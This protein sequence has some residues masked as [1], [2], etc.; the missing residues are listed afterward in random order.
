MYKWK[1]FRLFF[2]LTALLFGT[3]AWPCQSKDITSSGDALIEGNL[4][5]N[6]INEYSA[7]KTAAHI[8][9]LSKFH[10]IS[11]GSPGYKAAVKYVM[12]YMNSLEIF[13]VDAIKHTADGDKI[14]LQWRSMP[15]WEINEAELWLENT[16]ER[17]TRF[18]DVPVSVFVYSNAAD[19]S[20]EAVFI[21]EGISDE[22]YKGLDVRKKFVLATGDGNTVHK[23][24]VLERGA[25]GVIVGP[26][27]N[28][29]DWFCY[30]NLIP[31]HRLRSNK[32]LRKKTTFGFSLSRIQFQKLLG[33]LERG[34]ALKLH[35]KVDARQFDTE[36]ETVTA[37]LRG[38][39][40]PEKEI[41]FSAH[42]DHYSP[43]AND[44][45][46]G[47]AS[48]LE[49]ARTMKALIEQG[50]ISR[51]KRSIRFLWVG[52]MHGFAG[53]LAEDETIGERGIAG[54]NLD[55][56]GEDLFK[57]CS[58]LTLVRTPFSNPSFIADLIEYL[59]ERVDGLQFLT[60]T[61]SRQRLNYRV[62]N[63]KGGSDHFMLSDPT[64]GIPTVNIGHDNDI[65]HHTHMDDLDK[66]DTTELKRVGI[67]ST[68]AC[69][70]L[71]DA[72][73]ANALRLATKVA[74]QSLKRMADR[75][76]RN[77]SA[78][79]AAA[80]NTKH[81]SRIAKIL[82]ESKIF[83]D[84]QTG[85]EIKAIRS[86]EKLVSSPRL[87]KLTHFLEE[88]LIMSSE[89]EKK[90]L[91]YI[92]HDICKTQNIKPEPFTLS[93]EEK[94]MREIIPERLFRGPISQY[95]FE[96]LM[97]EEIE[98]YEDYGRKDRNWSNRR[99][100]ILNFMEGQR[101]LLDIYYAVS[102]EYGRSDPSFYL[103]FI[104]DLKKHGL[105]AYKN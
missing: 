65:F 66:I 42:L 36:T 27:A 5:R 95:Y 31:L 11:G 56:V 35:A 26:P 58:V 32:T 102:T 67:I 40:F 96:D 22:D 24:A 55:M 99:T 103:K 8:R 72:R 17:I 97:G 57:T 105:V 43:G 63:F 81:Q 47:S 100:E 13:E 45:N 48:L 59:I 20:G 21:G 98:W 61:G 50:I 77:L 104:E 28:N 74:A 82:E 83:S 46:S 86:I 88:E 12:D 89:A 92:F 33:Y 18:S 14:H 19:V 90:K 71:A 4:W 85:V 3:A 51:P 64:I 54:M 84:L 30:P 93:A 6:V 34:E 25:L 53:Y 16:G 73:E 75:S 68:A 78:L 62:S 70:Y 1:K 52:E 87:R 80:T 23:K 91:E 76:Q 9:E 60:P 69:V 39:Q 101:T 44:N 49:I 15:G 7:E 38:S 2:I 79:Y 29:T 10:R 37:V 41:I 94:K